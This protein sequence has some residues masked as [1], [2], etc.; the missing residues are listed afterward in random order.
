MSA[1]VCLR[2][3]EARAAY[4][5]CGGRIRKK[6]VVTVPS[7]STITAEAGSSPSC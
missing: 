3:P 5:H 4:R 2:P 6:E 7:T 1:V